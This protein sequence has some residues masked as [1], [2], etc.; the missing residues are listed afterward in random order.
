MLAKVGVLESESQREPWTDLSRPI[1]E[2][3]Q[4]KRQAQQNGELSDTL[5]AQLSSQRDS[6]VENIDV[7]VRR[8]G[9]KNFFAGMELEELEAKHPQ[10][11]ETHLQ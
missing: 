7:S 1:Y 6:R 9:T 2:R 11:L 4:L 8:S 3:L 10:R 5:L